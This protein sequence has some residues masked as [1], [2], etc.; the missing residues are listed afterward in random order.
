MSTIENIPE[1]DPMD[2][3]LAKAGIAGK[4]AIKSMEA[5]AVDPNVDPLDEYKAKA[6]IEQFDVA[7]MTKEDAIV[8]HPIVEVAQRDGYTVETIDQNVQILFFPEEKEITP[9][10]AKKTTEDM[11]RIFGISKKEERK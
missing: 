7:P 5:A 9:T 8:Y 10:Q 2:E 6:G 1:V 3:Y 11:H 4:N